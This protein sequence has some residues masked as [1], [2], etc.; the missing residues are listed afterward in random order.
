MGLCVF[1]DGW[2]KRASLT[3]IRVSRGTPLS[4]L[5]RRPHKELCPQKTARP[6]EKNI[7]QFGA[8]G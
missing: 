2:S 6:K 5:A 4:T 3:S 7:S 1:V 8:E